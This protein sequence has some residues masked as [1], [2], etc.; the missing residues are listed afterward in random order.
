MYKVLVSEEKVQMGDLKI[1]RL[2]DSGKV[3]KWEGYRKFFNI[4]HSTFDIHYFFSSQE[5]LQGFF[6]V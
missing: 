6:I 1:G 5:T 3:R 4:H 2:V